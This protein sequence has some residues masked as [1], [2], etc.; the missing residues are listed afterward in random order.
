MRYV[1]ALGLCLA[2]LLSMPGTGESEVNG[3]WGIGVTGNYEI[4]LF[5]LNSWFPSGGLNLGASIVRIKNASWTF[6]LDGQYSKY[7]SGDLEKRA[8]LFSGDGATHVS[9]SANSDMTW[10]SLGANFLYHFG[11]GGEKLESGGG[12]APYVVIGSGFYH[13]ENKMSGLIFP[14]QSG[15]T[16]DTSVLLRPEKDVRTALGSNVGF[17][18]EF[19]ASQ[20]VAIDIRG[21]YHVVWGNTRPMEAWGLEEAFPFH[22]FNAGARL[23]FYIVN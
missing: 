22:K 16:L 5:K 1:R 3:T 8:F 17:G 19:F 15:T 20:S 13:Y 9:P 10:I 6:E 2:L 23:K 12:G 11:Q 7:G 4:P 14:G 18:V 21:Q